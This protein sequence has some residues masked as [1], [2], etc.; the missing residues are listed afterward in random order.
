MGVSINAISFQVY[1][2][3][4]VVL[5]VIFGHNKNQVFTLDGLLI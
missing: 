4:I 5:T 1:T 3:I 2:F